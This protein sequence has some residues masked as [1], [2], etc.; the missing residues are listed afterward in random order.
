M[1]RKWTPEQKEKAR[2]AYAQ[3]TEGAAKSSPAPSAAPVDPLTLILSKLDDMSNR[4]AALEQGTPQY[5]PMQPAEGMGYAPGATTA[6]I[7]SIGELLQTPG[8]P[9]TGVKAS[10]P[11]TSHGPMDAAMIARLRRR[12]K[13]GQTVRINP[14]AVR[15]GAR[16]WTEH[17]YV[18]PRDGT[19]K[20]KKLPTKTPRPWAD[21]LTEL[22][23]E[24]RGHIRQCEDW[25]PRNGQWKYKVIIP[26]LTRAIG[27]GFYEYELLPA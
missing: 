22:G 14:E 5:R 23:I 21:V 24:G 7:P 1:G 27:D 18:D 4:V 6:E 12:F 13:Q 17:A 15:E 16:K 10:L 20:T 3:R 26:G 19:P 25:S 8:E 11:T 2:V 9:V